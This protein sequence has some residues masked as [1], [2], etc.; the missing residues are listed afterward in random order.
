MTAWLR[1]QGYQVNPKRARRVMRLMGLEA[2]YP[3]PRL[4]QSSKEHKIYPYLLK[5]VCIERADQVW[6]VDITYIRLASGFLYLVA[7]MDLFSRYVLAWEISIT[8]EKEFCLEAFKKAL[9]ISKPD[10]FNTDQGIQFRSL[11]F[12]GSLESSGIAISMDSRGR[13]FDNNF[14]KRLWR[15]VKYEEVYLHNYQTVREA[16]FG[17]ES[18]FQFY[19]TERLHSALGYLSPYEVYFK[20]HIDLKPG[21]RLHS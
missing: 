20:E 13:V 18:C 16:Y 4:S 10:I 6:G 8:L 9:T 7:I 1:K 5:A 11:E 19:K 3:K 21:Y 14:V 17:L 12:T 2:I 15:T